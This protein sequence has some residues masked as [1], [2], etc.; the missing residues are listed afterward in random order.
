MWFTLV[1]G[2]FTGF[3]LQGLLGLNGHVT[4]VGFRCHRWE[5]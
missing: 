1:T 3:L 2:G 5:V 4:T